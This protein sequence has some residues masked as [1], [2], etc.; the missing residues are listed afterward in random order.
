MWHAK[1][2]AKAADLLR[3]SL[4]YHQASTHMT[5]LALP[6]A[7]HHYVGMKQPK[8]KPP[9][10]GCSNWT[11]LELRLP[12]CCDDPRRVVWV[13][14]RL[15]ECQRL[16]NSQRDMIVQSH[17][18]SRRNQQE[19]RPG[20]RV[21]LPQTPQRQEVRIIIIFLTPVLNS[22]GM[23]KNYAMQYKKVQYYYYYYHTLAR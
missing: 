4:L 15:E 7:S 19:C 2:Q 5:I 14:N 8:K 13:A 18:R 17:C 6:E 12:K 11:S 10:P 20:G 22:Q 3:F 16:T 9:V 1:S 23:K 21:C